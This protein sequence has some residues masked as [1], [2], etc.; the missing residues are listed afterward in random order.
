MNFWDDSVPSKRSFNSIWGVKCRLKK[1]KLIN[2]PQNSADL[3][4]AW[5][6]QAIVLLKSTLSIKTGIWIDVNG[7]QMQSLRLCLISRSKNLDVH[8]KVIH[9]K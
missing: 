8:S 4:T 9:P 2:C 7:N 3:K 5:R 1:V 6:S